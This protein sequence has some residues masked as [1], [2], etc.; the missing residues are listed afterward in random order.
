MSDTNQNLEDANAFFSNPE[1][2]AAFDSLSPEQL[3][4]LYNSM[5]VSSDS[6]VNDLVIQSLAEAK[7]NQTMQLIYDF[8]HYELDVIFDENM[9]ASDLSIVSKELTEDLNVEG[10]ADNFI[11]T[12][13]DMSLKL[14]KCIERL[15]LGGRTLVKHYYD[16]RLNSEESERLNT[17]LRLFSNQELSNKV[18]E[19]IQKLRSKFEF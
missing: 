11:Y 10:D 1:N 18:E 8:L 5:I 14:K 4:E 16:F 7:R 9:K 12:S 15:P 17:Y 2:Q 3:N 13:D 19:V 6:N